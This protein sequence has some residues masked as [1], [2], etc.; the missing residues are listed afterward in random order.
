MDI[1]SQLVSA[2]NPSDTMLLSSLLEKA[3]K[4]RLKNEKS[5]GS[6]L[7]EY[8]DFIDSER[9]K[10]YSSS[11]KLS[12]RLIENHFGSSFNISEIDN[13][14]VE[15]FLIIIRRKAPKGYKVY[16]R[17]LKA[18]FNKAEQWG[19]VNKNPFKNIKLRKEQS[20]FPIIL[21]LTDLESISNHTAND[22]HK[23]IFLFAYYTGMRLGE[24]VNIRWGNIDLKSDL[25]TVGGKEF[26]TKSRQQRVIPI[27]KDLRSR[28]ILYKKQKDELKLKKEHFVFAK[29]NG[30]PYGED[31]ISK[32][33]KKACRKAHLDEE[34][35]F[36]TLRHSFA[37][38]LV[39]EG[40][41][42][43]TVKEL[44]GHQSI[45]TTE[46]YSHLDTKNL[47]KAVLKLDKGDLIQ[48]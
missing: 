10:K 39:Q 26:Q 23:E 8:C 17:N 48:K 31:Y 45:T 1:I 22:V 2:L 47:Q 4:E 24:V 28:L 12:C 42:L 38:K 11:V 44:L 5:L 35:H 20:S 27:C 29:N 6:F 21:E 18:A 41:N 46:V 19:Y 7:G 15:E 25:I 3:Q 34:I 36:H 43:Y 30:F 37:S 33:F 13:R 40:V 9:S 14:K 16:F 32:T